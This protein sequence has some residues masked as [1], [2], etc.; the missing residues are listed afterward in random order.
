MSRIGKKPVAIPAGVTA[1]IDGQ[2][3]TVKGGKGALSF[4]APE[5]VAVGSGRRSD[6]GRPRNETKRAR[7][8]WGMT[9]SM[10]NN[11]VTGVTKGFEQQ[12]RDHRRRLSRRR[13]RARTCN[14]RS[15]TAMT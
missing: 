14:C 12:A 2:L 10:V 1:K 3:V 9:R 6:Q 11:L 8:M 13:F 5:D 15:A 4:A 7:A